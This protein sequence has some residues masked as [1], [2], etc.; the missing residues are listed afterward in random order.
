MPERAPR[1]PAAVG[2]LHPKPGRGEAVLDGLRLAS[3]SLPAGRLARRTLLAPARLA[4]LARQG[5]LLAVGWH[6]AGE[7]YLRPLRP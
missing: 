1:A 7:P 4:L 2:R 3:W 6:R 5:A